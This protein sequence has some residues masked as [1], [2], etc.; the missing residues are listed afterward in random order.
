M[1]TKK[2]TKT[3]SEQNQKEKH[4]KQIPQVFPQ[5]HLKKASLHNQLFL[6]LASDQTVIPKPKPTVNKNKANHPNNLS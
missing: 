6:S 3:E 4:E 2:N 1:R 5:P